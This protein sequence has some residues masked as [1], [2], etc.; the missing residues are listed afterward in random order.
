MT[1]VLVKESLGHL[2][3]ELLKDQPDQALVMKL[4]AGLGIAYSEDNLT[5]MN[6]VLESMNKLCFNNETHPEIER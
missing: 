5:Q 4:T 6:T 2:V 1:D 3:D